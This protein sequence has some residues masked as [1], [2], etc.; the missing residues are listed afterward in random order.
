MLLLVFFVRLV[1]DAAIFLQ[2]L[3]C[4]AIM[5]NTKKIKNKMEVLHLG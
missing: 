4:G 2:N 1:Y 5:L 3:F